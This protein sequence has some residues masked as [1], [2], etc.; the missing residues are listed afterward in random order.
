MQLFS[1]HLPLIRQPPQPTI[2]PPPP[3][4]HPAQWH[5]ELDG[6]SNIFHIRLIW[7]LESLGFFSV[8]MF[9]FTFS[10]FFLSP[11]RLFFYPSSQYER[12][13][14]LTPQLSVWQRN[15]GVTCETKR[16]LYIGSSACKREAERLEALLEQM[17]LDLCFIHHYHEANL[18]L[19]F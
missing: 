8:M 17:T 1:S 4:P 9:F 15:E 5:L 3:P 12:H 10:L 16:A 18:T 2:S 11:Q 7:N 13:S 19:P 14:K 6:P